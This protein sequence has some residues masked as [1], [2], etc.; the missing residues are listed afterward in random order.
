MW[1]GSEQSGAYIYGTWFFYPTDLKLMDWTIPW[2]MRINSREYYLP[3][4]PWTSVLCST[5]VEW[6]TVKSLTLIQTVQRPVFAYDNQLNGCPVNLCGLAV[7]DL[8]H[9]IYGTW[10][11]YSTNQK[12]MGWTILERCTQIHGSFIHHFILG[13][14]NNLM[15]YAHFSEWQINPYICMGGAVPSKRYPIHVV[16]KLSKLSN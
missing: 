14:L 6:I 13:K 3:L 4:C 15:K 8:A 12:V 1:T 7:N 10:V 2:T 5:L 9:Y 11:F 16:S